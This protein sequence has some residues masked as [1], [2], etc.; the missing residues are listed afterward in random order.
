MAMDLFSL[1]EEPQEIIDL[2]VLWSLLADALSPVTQ[3][4]LKVRATISSFKRSRDNHVFFD[5]VQTKDVGTTSK[6]VTAVMPSIIWASASARITRSLDELGGH[7]LENDIEMVFIGKINVSERF[8]SVRFIV[9]DLDY[10]VLR[11]DTIIR[12]SEIRSRLVAEGVWQA[13]RLLPVPLVPLRIALITSPAGAVKS[14][15]E[16]P[17]QACE[18]NFAVDFFP[19]AVA[20]RAALVELPAA[21]SRAKGGSY[22]IVVL[23]RGGGSSSDLSTFNDENVVRAVASCSIPIWC[24]IGH[25]TDRET[26]LTSEVANRVFDV[27]QSVATSLVGVVESYLREVSGLASQAAVLSRSIIE[28]ESG[29]LDSILPLVRARIIGAVERQV[30]ALA[31]L[32]ESFRSIVRPLLFE[33]ETGMRMH[34]AEINRLAGRLIDREERNVIDLTESL[35]STVLTCLSSE[36]SALGL[37]EALVSAQD[38]DKILSLGYALV[39]GEGGKW[40][41]SQT[42]MVTSRRVKVRLHDGESEVE[43]LSGHPPIGP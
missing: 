26:V 6:Q 7:R 22:D 17:L 29:A 10:E 32:A 25:S 37:K 33:E 42:E 36:E 15:F 3:R 2:H 38:L 23:I 40:I 5:M 39:V 30:S 4:R 9:E 34:R 41:R 43:V 24:A 35:G 18:M 13:N 12:L 1:D 16:R 27:P 14:D 11:R 28:G 20:G 19:S 31:V 21:I 8:G